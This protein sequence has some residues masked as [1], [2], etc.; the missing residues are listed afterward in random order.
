MESL[1]DTGMVGLIPNAG[2]TGKE[3][4]KHLVLCQEMQCRWH[5]STRSM[6]IKE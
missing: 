2:V 5:R 4:G 3:E 6:A 1:V